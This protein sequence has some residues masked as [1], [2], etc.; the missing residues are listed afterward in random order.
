MAPPPPLPNKSEAAADPLLKDAEGHSTL[1]C[2]FKCPFSIHQERGG[3]E[4]VSISYRNNSRRS[5]SHN[6]SSDLSLSLYT[7]QE[8]DEK[9]KLM[10]RSSA[11]AALTRMTLHRQSTSAAPLYFSR[12]ITANQKKAWG[13][14]HEGPCLLVCYHGHAG[15][16]PSPQQRWYNA[17]IQLRWPAQHHRN[18]TWLPRLHQRLD[19]VQRKK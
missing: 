6:S 14:L 13:S 5:R 19:G 8:R 17:T 12:Q 2:P 10:D 1:R 9:E 15:H 3:E 7:R 16:R 18:S 4:A 11:A